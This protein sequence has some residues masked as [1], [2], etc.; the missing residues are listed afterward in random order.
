VA[1]C[2]RD[3]LSIIQY[4]LL[5]PGSLLL[6][7]REDPIS[8]LGKKQYRTNMATRAVL[9]TFERY[10][11][12]RVAFVSAVAE[13][14]KSP[15]VS[16]QQQRRGD[17]RCSTECCSSWHASPKHATNKHSNASCTL[18]NIEALQQAGAMAL[19]RPLLLDNVARYCCY[20]QGSRL[21]SSTLHSKAA[22]FCSA[23]ASLYLCD[24]PPRVLT[25]LSL[26][27]AASCLQHTA[28]CGPGAGA[29][30]KLQ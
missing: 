1:K 15:Q 6:L 27:F 16:K 12:E 28:V 8:C 4:T 19:L 26:F 25:G 11:K 5:C 10:Q 23:F 21:H 18:Q 7:S 9:Q 14:S 24:E 29:P 30:G 2:T 20:T 3:H 17:R 13:M 22:C